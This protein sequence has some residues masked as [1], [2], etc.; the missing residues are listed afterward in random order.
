ERLV[1]SQHEGRTVHVR[2]H[3]RDRE[4]LAAAGDAEQHLVLVPPQDPLGQLGDGARLVAT[5]LEVAGQDE[6]A[7]GWGGRQ[8]R[9]GWAHPPGRDAVGHP[10][11][12]ARPKVHAGPTWRPGPLSLRMGDRS[13]VGSGGFMEG[14]KATVIDGDSDVEG[15]LRGKDMRIL[16]RFRGEIELSGRLHL[17]EASRVEAKVTAES[18]EIAGEFKGDMV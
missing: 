7:V 9:L 11:I 5:C 2:E 16:G 1:V 12:I 13:Y 18:V 10:A 3:G 15:K 4:G 8:P 14:E 17:G 6:V